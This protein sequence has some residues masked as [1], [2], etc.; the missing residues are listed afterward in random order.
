MSE[1]IDPSDLTPAQADRIAAAIG[2]FEV[3]K[4]GLD[5]GMSLD[6]VLAADITVDVQPLPDEAQ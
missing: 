5:T 6:E 1:L 2:K 3:R 4:A